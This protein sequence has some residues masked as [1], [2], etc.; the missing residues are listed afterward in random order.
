MMMVEEG[1]VRR[2]RGIAYPP[3]D[4]LLCVPHCV[5]SHHCFFSFFSLIFC[6]NMD[7][8]E[9]WVFVSHLNFGSLTC[10]RYCMRVNP[11]MANRMVD[12]ARSVLNS[13]LPDVYI[14]TDAIKGADA[15][16]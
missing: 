14:Y 15:G 3:D 6:Q 7:V 11:A 5:W 13:Y 16:K 8:S 2:V 12:S 1:K 10:A 9:T 4:S